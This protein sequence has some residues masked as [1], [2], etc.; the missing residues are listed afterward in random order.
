MHAC[1]CAL[2]VL[3]HLY[4]CIH[5]YVYTYRPQNTNT[6]SPS[7]FLLS[8]SDTH[9]HT[10]VTT[11][12]CKRTHT[13]TARR[14]RRQPWWVSLCTLLV[15]CLVRKEGVSLYRG[16]CARKES[17]SSFCVS[18]CGMYICVYKYM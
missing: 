4:V 15:P 10:H 13:H 2:H 5:A 14:C 3:I 18:I 1:H 12:T 16:G 7:L 6:I 9:T 17:P 8:L 11:H